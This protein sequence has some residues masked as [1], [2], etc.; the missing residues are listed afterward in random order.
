MRGLR[1]KQPHEAEPVLDLIKAQ[2]KKSEVLSLTG[3]PEK[4]WPI[5]EAFL[6]ASLAMAK[7]YVS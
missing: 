1:V 6:K 4:D 3:N 2:V 5:R 7:N